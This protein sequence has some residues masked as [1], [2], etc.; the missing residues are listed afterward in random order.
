MSTLSIPGKQKRIQPPAP[1]EI[2]RRGSSSGEKGMGGLGSEGT[3]RG[4]E[5]SEFV[6]KVDGFF[7]AR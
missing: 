4:G 2:R 5:A 1:G 7:A 6:G 3:G